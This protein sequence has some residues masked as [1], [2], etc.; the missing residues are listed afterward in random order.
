MA[1]KV[2]RRRHWQAGQHT[3]RTQNSLKGDPMN[4]QPFQRSI[5]AKERVSALQQSARC[6]E[7]ARTCQPQPSLHSRIA[8]TLHLIANQLEHSAGLTMS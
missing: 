7:L 8:R 1:F 2:A 5:L 6:H 3:G 4:A